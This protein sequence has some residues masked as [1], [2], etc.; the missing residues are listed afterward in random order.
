M[1]LCSESGAAEDGTEGE[2]DIIFGTVLGTV[3]RSSPT[4]PTSSLPLCALQMESR[5]SGTKSY[6]GSTLACYLPLPPISPT[7][8]ASPLFSH[9]YP[10]SDGAPLSKL[11]LHSRGQRCPCS[12]FFSLPILP[13]RTHRIECVPGSTRYTLYLYSLSSSS[14][15]QSTALPIGLLS[16]QASLYAFC[17]SV[18]GLSLL[19][20]FMPYIKPYYV[21]LVTRIYVGEQLFLHWGLQ[22]STRYSPPPFFFG[23]FWLY[24]KFCS[25]HCLQPRAMFL[26]YTL[27]NQTM[28]LQKEGIEK[29][30]HSERSGKPL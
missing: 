19:L 17:L 8:P 4:A 28:V 16:N 20:S 5:F 30:R 1:V 24:Y 6:A 15:T 22:S 14:S 18:V 2:H 21:Y 29:K 27:S 3:S 7:K 9:P 10:V 11:L 13:L 23:W 12:P 26:Y 25:S